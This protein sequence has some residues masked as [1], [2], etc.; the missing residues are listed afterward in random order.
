M[1]DYPKHF[2]ITSGSGTATSQLVSFDNALI[3]AGISNYNLLRVSSILPIGC[4]QEK[5]I[6]EKEGSAILVAYASISSDDTDTIISSAIAVGIPKDPERVGVIMEYSG[7]C[8]A[9]VADDY[10]RK[11]TYEPMK[12]HGI[13][14]LDI[15]SSSIDA[16]VN[17]NGYKS[18]IS[19]IVM[20]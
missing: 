6:F 8:S 3:S 17:Q 14:C 16:I 2:L 10:V 9:S 15:Q 5:K 11:M 4:K 7:N 12:N 13:D 19:A 20:W 1:L 18:V